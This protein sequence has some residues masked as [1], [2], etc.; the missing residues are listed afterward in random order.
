MAGHGGA[1]R[2]GVARGAGRLYLNLSTRVQLFATLMGQMKGGSTHRVWMLQ[3]QA[4]HAA[5]VSI[6]SAN[7]L[8][9][10]NGA[11][12]GHKV[13]ERL[14]VL[15]EATIEIV[16]ERA[17]GLNCTKTVPQLQSDC[18][19]K[20]LTHKGGK[21]ELVQRLDAALG[22]QTLEW[23]DLEQV[24]DSLEDKKWTQIYNEVRSRVG[25]EAFPCGLAVRPHRV[26][27]MIRAIQKFTRV[28]F[29][30]DCRTTALRCIRLSNTCNRISERKMLRR[31][32]VS[33]F[34]W[35]CRRLNIPSS[36]AAIKRGWM[37]SSPI[38][39]AARRQRGFRS[40]Q[41]PNVVLHCSTA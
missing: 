11:T 18:K 41:D 29:R 39:T 23:S 38:Q 25:L 37:G 35:T 16:A 34:T 24:L 21:K 32:S 31:T 36:T 1:R 20:G 33:Y 5:G 7:D 4:N 2:G 9:Q 3:M 15:H 13:N 26:N 19:A 14:V 27:R 22:E 28:P 8:R 40:L 30:C 10:Y 17:K 6:R 12:F